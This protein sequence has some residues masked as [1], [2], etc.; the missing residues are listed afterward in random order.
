MKKYKIYFESR[1]SFIVSGKDLAEAEE[2]AEKELNACGF[3]P[4]NTQTNVVDEL[5]ITDAKPLCDLCESPED[6][7]GRCE[8]TIKE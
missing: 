7:D 3:A 1:G 2:I 4:E 6:D 8:C 5:E